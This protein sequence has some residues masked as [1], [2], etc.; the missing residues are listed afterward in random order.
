MTVAPHR[1]RTTVAKVC[2]WLANQGIELILG[3]F[4]SQP[5]SKE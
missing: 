3:P 4:F 1:R 5:P 2:G